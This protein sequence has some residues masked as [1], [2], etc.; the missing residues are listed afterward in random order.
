MQ[1]LSKVS[2]CVKEHPR[3]AATFSALVSGGAL[4][5]G[6]LLQHYT[7]IDLGAFVARVVAAVSNPDVIQ[8]LIQGV[9]AGT[10]AFVGVVGGKFIANLRGRP[11]QDKL[12]QLQSE[13]GRKQAKLINISK[14]LR[15]ASNET[16]EKSRKLCAETNA[17]YALSNCIKSKS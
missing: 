10:G 14:Q 8:G 3:L 7:I 9:W 16:L 1:L 5:G 12:N 4:L 6:F 15:A 2:E 11:S 17:F 13:M